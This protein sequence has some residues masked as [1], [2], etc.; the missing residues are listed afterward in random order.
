M[1]FEPIAIVGQA[2]TLPSA[3][4]PDTLWHNVLAGKS[5]VTS[6]PEGRFRL[7]AWHAMG[8]PGAPEERI[9]NEWAA[10]QVE[11]TVNFAPR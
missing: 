6:P 10:H 4:T 8:T 1:T 7:P 2:C 5:A 11:T 9:A 3:L